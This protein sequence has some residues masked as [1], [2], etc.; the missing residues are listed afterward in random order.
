MSV[1]G[2]SLP[3]LFIGS[4]SKA[5]EDAVWLQ[6]LLEKVSMPTVWGS[7]VFELSQG[8]LQSLVQEAT[9]TDFA[10]FLL[11]PDDELLVGD[12]STAA[13][14]DNVIFE[15]GLFAGVLGTDRVFLVAPSDIDLKLP[16]D[17]AGHTIGKYK[18]RNDGR[19]KSALEPVALRIQDKI[20]K[21][22][23]R[24][25][26]VP[27]TRA[28]FAAAVCF[29]RDGSLTED[30]SYL[31]VKSS[32]GRWMVPKCAILPSEAPQS[33]ALRCAG[34]EGGVFGTV[35]SSEGKVFEYLK[36]DTAAKQQII[37]FTLEYGRSIGNIET[38]REPTWFTLED[39]IAQL[40][41][42]RTRVGYSPL[43]EMLRWA[44]TQM[45]SHP[46][47]QRKTIA[48][49]PYQITGNGEL[50]FLLITSRTTKRWI[51]PK[52]HRE[53]ADGSGSRTAAREASEEGGITGTLDKKS[54]GTYRARS[55]AFYSEIKVYG[56]HVTA[57]SEEWQE[58][59]ARERKWASKD[60]AASLVDEVD[61]R[62]I[63][64]EFEPHP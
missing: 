14:R 3:S 48:A 36:E 57:L 29:R 24:A 41:K 47:E 35:V 13:P 7:D 4:S 28:D 58:S 62:K 19:T 50:R 22:G 5:R 33:A 17:F 1:D 16:S 8:T 53:E 10:I 46:D 23:P 6:S 37:A 64:Q 30:V 39:A 27:R 31:L 49:L 43:Q 18:T 34:D 52:G 21:L 55:G 12:E 20:E 26:A 63:I 45:Q 2:A 44:E 60:E 61:L 32:R 25:V 54:A 51:I 9:N 42:D 38:F 59:Y 11:T 56:L 15:A 40:A